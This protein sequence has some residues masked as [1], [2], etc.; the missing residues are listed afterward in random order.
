LYGE[1][2]SNYEATLIALDPVKAKK[3]A[4][5]IIFETKGGIYHW[6]NCSN[7]HGLDK[8]VMMIKKLID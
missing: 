3:L 2:I 6:L 7:K 4:K 5:A 8:E 1:D